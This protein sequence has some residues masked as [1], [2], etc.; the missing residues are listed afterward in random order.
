MYD[1]RKIPKVIH[2]IFRVSYVVLVAATGNRHIKNHG[3]FMSYNSE[4]IQSLGDGETMSEAF[5]VKSV[6]GTE[7]TGTITIT[8]VNDTPVIDANTELS[9]DDTAAQ[10]LTGSLQ[11]TDADSDATELQYTITQAASHGELLMNGV[12]ITD[13]TNAVFTQDDIDKGL[14]TFKFVPKAGATA[15]ALTDDSFSFTVSDGEKTTDSQTFQIRNTVT[16]VW[17]TDGAEDLTG[18]TNYDDPDATFHVYGFDGHDTLRGGAN[19]DTLDGGA[20]VDTADYGASEAAVNI[21]LR[22]AGAQSGGDARGDILTGIENVTGSAFD[23]SIVGNDAANVLLG[24]DGND[25]LDGS[26]GDDTLYGGSGNDL[27][28]SCFGSNIQDRD[29]LH[30]GAGDDTLVGWMGG[31]TLDGGDGIDTADYGQNIQYFNFGV[32]VDLSLGTTNYIP[33]IG[34]DVLI[35]IENVIGAGGFDTL[36]GSD[37]ANL[38]EGGGGND[39]LRGLGGDDTMRGGA[40]ADN[41]DGGAGVDMADYSQSGAA[42]NIDLRLPGAQSGGDAEGDILKGIEN[43]IGSNH[44]DTIIGSNGTNYLYGLDGNDNVQAAYG[45]DTL[46]GGAGN[47]TLWGA[48]GANLVLGGAGD[49]TLYGQ[50]NNDTLV[51]GAGADLLDG[52]TEID[53]ADYSASEAAVNIDLRLPGAQSG[54]DAEGD[55]LKGIENII[56]SSHN[57]TII[58]HNGTNYLYGLD[59]NDNVQAAYGDDTLDGGAGNDT[60][61]GA[62]GAN[63]VLGGAGDD[64][65]YGQGNND[66]LVGGAGADLLDGGTEIDTA[67]YSASEAAVNIDLRLPGAQSGGDAEGDILKGIENIIGSS[68]N[69]TIIGHN[70]TNYLYGGYGNDSLDGGGG[71]DILSGGAG[72]DTING[73]RGYD[74]ASYESSE[75]GVNVDLTRQDGVQTQSGGDAEGDVLTGIDNLTGSNHDDVLTGASYPNVLNGLAGNDTITAGGGNHVLMGGAGADVIDGGTG[76]DTASYEGSGSG[77]NVDLTRQGGGQTQSGGDAEGDVLVSIENLT[78]SNLGDV[79]KGNGVANVLTGLD[80][81]DAITAGAGDRVDGGAG[82]D[83]LYSSDAALNIADSTIIS[84]VERVDLTGNAASL[85]VNGAAILGNGVLDPM[86]GAMKALIVT[87]DAGDVVHFSGDTWVWAVAGE[88]QTLEGKT[89]TVY[90][91]TK[92]GETVRLYVQTGLVALDVGGNEAPVIAL[93]EDL[94]VVDGETKSLTGLLQTTDAD[95]DASELQYTITQTPSHGVL[96]LNGVAI[97][98]FTNAAFTQDDIDKGLVTFKFVPKAGA[99]AQALTD[100]SFSFAVSDGEK[101][102]DSQTFQIRNTVTQVWGTNGADDLTGLTNYDDPDATFHVYGFD[103]NDTLRGVANAD[104]LD[105]GAGIDTVDYSSS[106]A[107]VEVNLGLAT[108]QSGGE[109]KGDV[110]IDIENVTGST[111]GDTLI[112]DGKNNLLDGGGGYDVLYGGDGDDLML[113]G[114]DELGYDTMYGGSGNDT[115]YG[116]RNSDFL[117]GGDGNDFLEGARHSYR[118]LTDHDT[119]DGGD[120]N[121][122][123]LGGYGNDLIIGG[124]GADTIDGWAGI[125]T[126]DYSDSDASVEVNLRLGTGRG[127]HAEG[128]VIIGIVNVVG[129]THED[130]LIGGD[131]HER[132]IMRGYMTNEDCI[133]G[134]TGIDQLDYTY[135]AEDPNAAHALD[136]VTGVERIVL[137]DADTTIITTNGFATN[138]IYYQ[139]RVVAIRA[140]ALTAG[141]ALHLDASA[142][143]SDA[144]HSGYYVTG[145]AGN[146]TMIGGAGKDSLV[147]SAGDDAITAGAGDTVDGGAGRDVLYSSDATLDI[148]NSTTISG[149]ESVDLTGSATSLTVNGDAILSNGAIDPMD[150]GMKALV[151]TG[152]AGDAVRFSG[153]TWAWH[154]VSDSQTLGDGKT[155]TVYE[156]LKDGETVRLY[157]HAGLVADS[158]VNDAP[159]VDL[160]A[161]LHVNDA[162]A[163]SLTGMLHASDTDN[164]AAEIT[165]SIVS[166]PAHG[167]VMLNGVA[168]TDFTNAAFTQDDIEKGLVTFKFVPKAGATAQ[169]L[170]DDSFSFAVSDGEKTTDSQTFQIRNTVTQ[171]WGTDGKDDLNGLTNYDNPDA[172]FHVYGFDGYDTLRGGVNADTLDGGAGGDT[173]NYSASDAAVQVNLNL[174]GQTGGHAEGDELI[175]IE[176]VTG[177]TWGDTLIG[178]NKNNLL[179]GGGGRDV[180]HGGD[181]NDLMRGGGDELGYDTMYG[182]S[183]NDTLYGGRSSDSLVGGDGNDRLQGDRYSHIHSNGQD[184]LDGGAGNDSI[185]GGGGNDRII[186]GAGA[187]TLNGWVGFDTADYSASEAAVN[188]DLRR[189]GAQFGGDARGDILTRIESIVGSNHDDTIIGSNGA[190]ILYGMDGNDDVRAAYGND[191]LDGGSGDDTLW[192]AR[193]VNLLLGGD[194]NDKLYG[195]GNND[196]LV[197]GAGADLLDGGTGVDTASY[198]GSG[199]GV[200]VDLTRQGGGQTQS[201]GD[202]QGDVF[203]SIENLT[204]SNLGDV[205]TGSSVANILNGLDGGDTITA[206][207]GDTVDGGG[208]L[209]VLYSSDAALDIVDSTSISSV[210]RVDLTGSATSLTVSGDAIL[211]NGAIDPMDSGMKALVVTGDAG[212]AV[213]FSGDT[214]AWHIV[215]DSQTLG[216]GQSY[217]VYESTKDGETVRLYV[218]NGMVADSGLNEAPTIDNNATL[219][220][221]DTATASLTG[222]LHASDTDNSA[223]DLTYSIVSGP[224]HGVVMLNGVAITDFTNA[225]FTQ[226]DIEKGLVTF[227]FVPKAGATAQALT[228]DSFS[229]AV[230]DGEKTTDSQTFQ[231]RN[232]VTQVWGT[233]G[234]DDVTGLANYDD[235]D[236]TFHA[237]GFDGDDIL[238]GGAGRDT[239]YGGTGDDTLIGGAGADL[240]DGGEGID[241]VDYSASPTWVSVLI[242]AGDYPDGGAGNHAAGDELRNVEIVIGSNDTVHGDLITGY[243]SNDELHGLAG[244]D[245]LVGIFGYDTLYGGAGNDSLE[246]SYGQMYGGDGNDTLVGTGGTAL[247]V[248][249]AGADWLDGGTGVETASYEGS[250]SGVNVDLTRQGGGQTQSGGDAEGDVLIG[251]ENLT[252]SNL[253]DVLTGS[254]VANILNGLDGGDTITAG[255][256]D[257]VDGGGGL[258]VLYSSDAVLDIVDST[259]ISSVERV[260]LTG[261][262]TSL[263]VSGDAILSNGAIDPLDSGRKALVVTGDAGDTVHFSGDSWAWAVAGENQTLEDKTYTVYEGVKDGEQVRLYIQTGMDVDIATAQASVSGGEIPGVAETQGTASGGAISGYIDEFLQL[264][265]S[266]NL[267]QDLSLSISEESLSPD[268]LLASGGDTLSGQSGADTQDGSGFVMSLSLWVEPFTVDGGHDTLYGGVDNDTLD[269]SNGNDVLYGGDGNDYLHGGKGLGFNPVGHVFD[270]DTLDGGSGDD[271]LDGGH[272]NDVLHGGDGNDVL[273]GG[274][275]IYDDTLDGG[276]GDDTMDGDNGN[277]VLRGGD[278]NDSLSGSDDNWCE[279]YLA[280]KRDGNYDT[281]DGGNGNDTLVGGWG[282][283]SLMGGDGDDLLF[284]GSGRDVMDG[285]SGYDTMDGGKGCDIM[286]GG[287]GNDSMFG[288]DEAYVD[289]LDSLHVQIM[290]DFYGDNVFEGYRANGDTM[291]GGLGNDFIRGGDGDDVLHGG[292]GIDSL[293]G[294][295]GNDIL[296]LNLSTTGL[297]DSNETIL[298]THIGMLDGG[299][300]TDTLVLDSHGG[301]G[302]TLDLSSLVTAGKIG[303]IERID[304][305]GGADDNNTLTLKASDVFSTSGGNSLFIDGDAGDTVTMTDSGWTVGADVTVDG[306]TYRHYVNQGYNLY[307]DV[308]I[309]QQNIIH[310]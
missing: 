67:D 151:V 4:V 19:A 129:S 79:L 172:T 195:Q 126:A 78:G 108:A 99:T 138:N 11:V 146:D 23:D 306:Q 279:Y 59:G 276:S 309:D 290:Q 245:T 236:A 105:G 154:I 134:G 208:G 167:V 166:G 266:M 179:D 117:M 199:S 295:A 169:A 104:T 68:H 130:T 205:L 6:D 174:V 194:G 274:V 204:G 272:G 24:L 127:G 155:Y 45:D 53:T 283:D 300:G 72:A 124:P 144:S 289:N 198:E 157:V 171:V 268:M 256:G 221:N 111:L 273:F 277:D 249:G 213:R 183:G 299:T 193:D 265:L 207:A 226:D 125:D 293:F 253:G 153:D 37:G 51:G 110:L 81:D 47:D 61:W 40:G 123:L 34:E 1:L 220:V 73:G 156:G 184:T 243:F 20:G 246:A 251:I 35:G 44:N 182:G 36:T 287:D 288:G 145:G 286:F 135:N 25:R 143:L 148:A 65:L 280:F 131:V 248:G 187:D 80:G 240:L 271:I 269:G 8:G 147:G 217:A 107:A 180:L 255:A 92:D 237:Y 116:G 102:T 231:I 302:V 109:A 118:V 225:A 101:T 55:I 235:P 189:I 260:D 70:G 270:N 281:M 21:N 301:S 75:S 43:V 64:T 29:A 56:G 74:T 202:A 46:D 120:G 76:V 196:T 261:S 292:G 94:Q 18:L 229:F 98:D 254:S 168:I 114:D 244:D 161:T 71:V 158:D 115:L 218:H 14:V 247:L 63:L 22:R 121:D 132:F 90:E 48:T 233:N 186:G 242:H 175:D 15:Q 82:L 83:V 89:Y 69:D 278:G 137:G 112:G 165:Y 239:L 192:G 228:D 97:T 52:G 176:N 84:G 27:L 12:A 88:N 263:T 60:L 304:I 284:G 275:G 219:H 191:T 160:N 238:Y 32:R 33:N 100:D 28:Y 262:A 201:G 85:T 307:I 308:E 305:T 252:G 164:S 30:G 310:S 200:N 49:D 39:L 185:L 140:D 128:D 163:A 93:N 222:M 259:S 282:E 264:K 212:D 173:A 296:H 77:V 178:D 103:G 17:G 95:N 31:D 188:I 177:S 136:H 197:G 170:T 211:S 190:D 50:G 250:L 141:H 149:V 119:L 13:F 122:F 152:D 297:L 38:L 10:S 106:S 234:A 139:S 258:D 91:G 210:E 223:S 54:G 206:G 241:T 257:T 181:G 86:G 58:G 42:V 41:I 267:D 227:K 230:S 87:G 209:D 215:S 232:T 7:Q 62:T 298:P 96:T 142:D 57:D 26:R 285:G 16:Q 3:G 162:A 303:G 214:W 203:V 294:D 66:T 150:S 159:A 5:T 9:V 291:D 224:A 113:G 216:D 2:S 133:E